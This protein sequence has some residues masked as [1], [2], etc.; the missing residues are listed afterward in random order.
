MAKLK[1]IGILFLAKFQALIMAILGLICGLVYSLGGFFYE[2]ASSSLNTGTALAF[3]ALVGMPLIFGAIGFAAG[4]I[5]ALV[6][7]WY[8]RL[9]GGIEADFDID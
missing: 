1:R 6:Y 7:N 5:E 3:L 8:A 9:A 2:L 4:I